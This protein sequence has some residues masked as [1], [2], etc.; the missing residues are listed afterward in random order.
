MLLRP[1]AARLVPTPGACKSENSQ[2][3]PRH[4]GL[5]VWKPLHLQAGFRLPPQLL[6]LASPL[7]PTLAWPPRREVGG[8]RRRLPFCAAPVGCSPMKMAA[9]V[10]ERGRCVNPVGL[11]WGKCRRIRGYESARPPLLLPGTWLCPGF[12]KCLQEPPPVPDPI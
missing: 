6:K 7:V 1:S 11:F 5:N 2:R 12:E 9:R 4:R 3:F 8:E 10:C